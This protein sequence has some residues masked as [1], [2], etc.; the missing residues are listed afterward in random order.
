MAAL[1]GWSDT[2]EGGGHR[3]PARGHESPQESAKTVNRVSR[4]EVESGQ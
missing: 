4:R 1:S 3:K 2:A